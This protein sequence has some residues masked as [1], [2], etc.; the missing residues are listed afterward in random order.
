VT[1][2]G[3]DPWRAPTAHGPVDAVVPV[4]GSKSITNRLLV[5]AAIAGTP[6]TIR[7]PLHARDTMLMAQALRALGVG[8]QDVDDPDPAAA[9]GW[10]V[11]PRPLLGPATVDCGLAGT[12]M[13]FVPPLAALA[14]GPVAF[15]GDTRARE[16]PMGA[17]LQAL[18]DLGVRVDAAPGDRLPFATLGTG[19]VAGGR[20]VIDASG[21]SQFVSALLLVGA[22]F[23]HGVEVSSSAPVPSLPHVRM[24]VDLL[25]RS[26]VQVD[27][28]DDRTWRVRPGAPE[29]GEV[30][31]EPDLSNAMPFIAAALITGGRVTVPGWP[32]VSLQPASEVLA[33]IERLGGRATHGPE[34]LSV[35]AERPPMLGALDMS[36]LGELVP[37]VAAFAALADEPTTISGVAHLRGHETDR[38]AALVDGLRA[39]GGDAE[40][41]HDG[42]TIRPRPLHGGRWR[43][44]DDHRM[45]TAGA[46]LGLRVPGLD[47][48]NIAT[49]GKTLPGFVPLWNR[50]LGQD[51]VA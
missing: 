24:T 43:T 51:Q 40:E 47:V 9:R 31:V 44:Y 19:R 15:D 26:H 22:R 20:V 21:S 34:G 4:P 37:T 10:I 5:L 11:E 18:R 8:G 33:L 6:T 28:V 27:E 30:V 13:R 7:N 49:T 45:A 41:T 16:R 1:D 23:E 3:L 50:L 38:L 46:I 32:K 25:R 48:E 12:V 17:L 2:E 14:D 39:L 35:S 29:L 42:L 36:A